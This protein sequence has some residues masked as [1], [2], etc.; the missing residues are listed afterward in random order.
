MHLSRIRRGLIP[1]WVNL[2]TYLTEMPVMRP[3]GLMVVTGSRGFGKLNYWE[4]KKHSTRL[5]D[6]LIIIIIIILKPDGIT[7]T[8]TERWKSLLYYVTVYIGRIFVQSRVLSRRP[9]LLSGAS[10]QISDRCNWKFDKNGGKNGWQNT[11]RHHRLLWLFYSYVY[12]TVKQAVS[13]RFCIQ[14]M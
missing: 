7:S 11:S 9:S 10:L 4:K 12:V 14:F 8:T 13:D 6:V 1:K 3:K 2:L 5:S